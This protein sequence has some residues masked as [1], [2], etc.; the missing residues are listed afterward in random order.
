MDLRRSGSFFA[1]SGSAKSRWR[2]AL[3]HACTRRRR[4]RIADL[5][6]LSTRSSLLA[7]LFSLQ[8]CDAIQL[9]RPGEECPV[10][11]RAGRLERHSCCYRSPRICALVA[12]AQEVPGVSFSAR[13]ESYAEPIHRCWVRQFLAFAS[14][15]CGTCACSHPSSLH[16]AHAQDGDF[17]KLFEGI[18]A[19]GRNFWTSSSKTRGRPK[20]KLLSR[21]L[22][23]SFRD[24]AV[25]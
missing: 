10:L 8:G 6:T 22:L 16:S 3:R 4:R 13:F 25:R 18:T 12:V 17:F 7:M 21:S 15:G 2:R 19:A 24:K 5:S 20:Y 11:L 23:V 1:I 9:G 14:F